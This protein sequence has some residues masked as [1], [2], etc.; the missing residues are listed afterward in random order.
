MNVWFPSTYGGGER[1]VRECEMDL[2][3]VLYLKWIANKDLLC[4]T[5][6]SAECYVAAGWERSLGENGYMYMYGWVTQLCIWNCQHCEL[7][8]LLFSCSVAS[9]SLPPHGLQHTRLPS[10]SPSP[11]ACSSSRPLT[12]W[13][14]TP[15][16]W[17]ELVNWLYSDVKW[18]G[19]GKGQECGGEEWGCP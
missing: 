15:V 18:K 8:I 19:E 14:Y 17:I 16:N 1:I 10:P 4:S 9:D 12:K 6:N 5:E 7:A 2:Y 11:G 3:T 13:C